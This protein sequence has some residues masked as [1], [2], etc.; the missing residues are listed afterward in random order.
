MWSILCSTLTYVNS[1]EYVC[2]ASFATEY[3][4]AIYIWQPFLLVRTY[5]TTYCHGIISSYCI[6]KWVL[7]IFNSMK[8]YNQKTTLCHPLIWLNRK[9]CSK[10]PSISDSHKSPL[11]SRNLEFNHLLESLGSPLPVWYFELTQ[12]SLGCRLKFQFSQTS[13]FCPENGISAA[14]S[15]FRDHY[16]WTVR[17]IRVC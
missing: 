11:L 3:T 15:T 14:P 4:H 5:K 8:S 17:N 1:L 12:F 2:W 16:S 10:I 9:S 6:Q 7:R 13:P